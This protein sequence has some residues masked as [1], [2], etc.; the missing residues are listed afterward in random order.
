MSLLAEGLRPPRSPIYGTSEASPTDEHRGGRRLEVEAA[1]YKRVLDSGK[2]LP[3]A[4]DTHRRR[5]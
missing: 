5:A 2:A 3:E 1:E 4:K